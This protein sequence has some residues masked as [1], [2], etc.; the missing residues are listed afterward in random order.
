MKLLDLF[1]QDEPR[2]KLPADAEPKPRG[3]LPAADEDGVTNRAPVDADGNRE[4]DAEPPDETP[5]EPPVDDGGEEDV[6]DT[7]GQP[8]NVGDVAKELGWAK[9]QDT[10]NAFGK[11]RK[12]TLLTKDGSVG[13]IDVTQQYVINPETGAWKFQA[14]CAGGTEVD[15]V[16]FA[17]GEDPSSLVTHLRKAKKITPHQ[18]VEYLNPPVDRKEHEVRGEPVEEAISPRQ[19]QQK[20][21]DRFMGRDIPSKSEIIRVALQAIKDATFSPHDR[22]AKDNLKLARFM[23]D[24]ARAYGRNWPELKA[25]EKSIDT[26]LPPRK[27]VMEP[28]PDEEHEEEYLDD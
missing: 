10:L 4:V 7:S 6:E 26:W 3:K 23:V 14:C 8:E 20:Y 17:T 16:E 22:R 24:A 1:E 5:E 25:I 15:M 18:A 12:V 28:E 27:N 11:T 13:G 9:T 19:L 21:A 2:D